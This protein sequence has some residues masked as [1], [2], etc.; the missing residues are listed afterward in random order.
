MRKD[1]RVIRCEW[2]PESVAG[3]QRLIAEEHYTHPMPFSAAT[4]IAGRLNQNEANRG[5]PKHYSFIVR[6][7]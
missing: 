5:Y 2:T 1:Y 7:C 4:Q 6:E 3:I